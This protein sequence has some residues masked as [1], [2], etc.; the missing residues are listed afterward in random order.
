MILFVFGY[1][2]GVLA[3]FFMAWSLA[4]FA[5]RGVSREAAAKV[6]EG[7]AMALGAEPDDDSA[8]DEVD[9]VEEVEETN[10]PA[11][12]VKRLAANNTNN[13]RLLEVGNGNNG[14]RQVRSDDAGNQGKAGQGKNERHSHE[15]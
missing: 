11:R 8:E 6:L 9:D 10:V 4:W 13:R 1:C 7:A 3:A 2:M 15:P 5:L 14:H 12:T